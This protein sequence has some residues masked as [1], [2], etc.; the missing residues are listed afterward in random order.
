M[1]CDPHW[2]A[3]SSALLT[4]IVAVFGAFI[5]FRQW[6][7]GQNKLKLEL[8]DRRFSVY[9]ASRDLLAGIMTSGR[10]KD[11]ET[12][13]FLAATRE[14]KWL[15][16]A[17][18]EDYL[19]KA[20]YHQALRLACLQA[21]LEGVGVGDERTKNVREQSEIKKWFMSQYDVLDAYFSKYMQ[22]AH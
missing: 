3:Y 5:A 20:L 22:L 13:K 15:L 7:L 21:E 6:R 4:P 1:T 12:F 2:T 9:A 8:F 19:H 10:A 14:A 17:E 16:D 11:E 18:I